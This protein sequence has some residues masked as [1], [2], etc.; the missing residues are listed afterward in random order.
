MSSDI[1][2]EELKVVD[3]SAKKVSSRF[4]S[5]ECY[6]KTNNKV[7][8]L[9]KAKDIFKGDVFVVAQTAGILAAKNVALL[10]PLCHPILLTYVNVSISIAG[11]DSIYVKSEVASEGK[12]GPDVEAMHAVSTAAITIFDMCKA[13]DKEIVIEKILLLEKKGGKSGE[14]KRN[15]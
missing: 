7:I 8:E 11:C 6:V 9:I 10:I 2:G 3:I 14:F 12:T 13:Y 1:Q 5:A 4:A 15:C